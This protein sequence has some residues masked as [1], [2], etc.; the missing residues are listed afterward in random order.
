[1]AYETYY[2][3]KSPKDK[4]FHCRLCRKMLHAAEEHSCYNVYAQVCQLDGMYQEQ[5]MLWAD[6][7]FS[8]CNI[9][10]DCEE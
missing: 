3:Y 1:M 7:F 8:M 6:L 4:Q 9:D 5:P 10:K 2:Q